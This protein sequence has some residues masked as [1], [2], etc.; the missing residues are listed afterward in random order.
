M[1]VS[2]L[3]QEQEEM[4]KDKEVIKIDKEELINLYTLK[5][6]GGYEIAKNINCDVRTV[7]KRLKKFGIPIRNNSEAQKTLKNHSGRFKKGHTV[8]IEA[9]KKLK[10]SM[11]GNK[12]W[13]GRKH[14]EETK[15]K[16]R[17]RKCS[18]ETRRK[19]SKSAKGKTGENSHRWKGGFEEYYHKIGRCI[20]IK[21]YGKIPNGCLIHHIDGN[22]KNNDISNLEMMTRPEH[23]RIHNLLRKPIFSP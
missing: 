18:I 17:A 19:M 16:L 13:L 14:A 2:L 11:V 9:R 5:K 20:Y 6:L 3:G 23:V 7:Y 21:K 15:Q 10:K 1:Q 12:I 22:M 8:S 4:I